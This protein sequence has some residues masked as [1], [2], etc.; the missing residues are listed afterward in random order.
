MQAGGMERERECSPHSCKDP[1]LNTVQWWRVVGGPGNPR[2]TAESQARRQS[3]AVLAW[4]ACCGAG[5]LMRGSRSCLCFVY[6]G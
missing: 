4:D 1:R 2:E 6:V 3:L 5:T